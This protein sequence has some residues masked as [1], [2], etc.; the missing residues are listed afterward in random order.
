MRILDWVIPAAFGFCMLAIIA[1][2]ILA[3]ADKNEKADAAAAE[4]GITRLKD[5]WRCR[6][7]WS[8]IYD[9]ALTGLLSS[10]SAGSASIDEISDRAAEFA[11]AKMRAM[12]QRVHPGDEFCGHG[13]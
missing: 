4:A 1:M 7:L 9:V 2:G 13:G 12:A 10:A 6:Q 5:T 8:D 3:K 11:D